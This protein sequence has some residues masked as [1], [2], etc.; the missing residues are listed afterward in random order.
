MT[1][2]EGFVKLKTVKYK[3][4]FH[5]IYRSINEVFIDYS[6]AIIYSCN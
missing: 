5:T 4:Q 1:T 2:P 6:L 3:R